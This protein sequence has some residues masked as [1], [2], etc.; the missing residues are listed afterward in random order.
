MADLEYETDSDAYVSEGISEGELEKAKKSVPVP[1]AKKKETR[2]RKPLKDIP[3]EK[4]ERVKEILRKAQEASVKAR[5]PAG[6]IRKK[7]KELYHIDLEARNKELDLK[8]QEANYKLEQLLKEEEKK[9]EPVK[10]PQPKKKKPVIIVESES[11]EEPII[12]K[13]K[14]KAKKVIVEET[15]SDSDVKIKKK[16]T[17]KIKEEIVN[18]KVAE[19]VDDMKN[20]IL[21][22][23]M[24]SFFP[25]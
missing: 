22:E 19:K 2:G 24:K 20:E 13:K 4:Q 8:L 12:I 25:T 9:A 18:R 10:A 5:K 23:Y 3:P 11:E 15:S 17:N 16:E 7:K 1:E 21:R 6:D 14:K